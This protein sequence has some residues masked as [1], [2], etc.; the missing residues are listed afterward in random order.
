MIYYDNAATTFPKPDILYQKIASDYKQFGVNAGRSNYSLARKSSS[1][2]DDSRTKLAQ[3]FNVNSDKIHFTPS[4]TYA[5]NQIIFGLNIKKHSSIYISPFEHNA[6]TRP[7]EKLKQSKNVNV[8]VLEFEGFTI[9]DSQFEDFFDCD[10]LFLTHQSNVTGLVLSVN[11]ICQKVKNA[12]PDVITVVDGAQCG[13]YYDL[14]WNY[15][16]FY[17]FSGHKSLYGPTGIA[18]FINN[19]GF[20][21]V[22]L[23]YGGTGT[24]SE[25]YFMP[26]TGHSRYEAG[27]PNLLSIIGLN[28][29]LTWLLKTGVDDITKHQTE[30]TNQF[31][32]FLKN[33]EKKFTVY[34]DE[35]NNFGGTVLFNVKGKSSQEIENYLSSKDICVRSGLHCSP[36]THNH[37][38]TLKQGGAVRFSAGFFNTKQELSTLKDV[39]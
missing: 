26:E 35:K 28:A 19:S 3:L 31:Y 18:G 17:C 5:L 36:L 39:L 12:S 29:S 24:N 33:N 32:E 27:S 13:G 4:I 9:D 14:D 6:V 7:L 23:V 30:I 8:E 34:R 16:D 1:V 21:I 25:S 22:P 15:I 10:V 37:I 11:E 38:G 2:I 20:E